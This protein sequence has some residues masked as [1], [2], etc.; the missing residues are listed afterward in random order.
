MYKAKARGGS[1]LKISNI[2]RNQKYSKKTTL[3]TSLIINSARQT[4]IQFI[5]LIIN[6]N[7]K[8][9]FKASQ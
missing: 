2:K 6:N 1:F 3:S 9:F 5:L 4:Y 8:L 7:L